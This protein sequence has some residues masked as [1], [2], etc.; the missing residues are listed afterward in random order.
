MQLFPL[1][2]RSHYASRLQHRQVLGEIGFRNTESLLQFR[3][4]LLAA[5]Q[6]FD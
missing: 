4:P 5:Q 3:G 1:A 2:S 6:H